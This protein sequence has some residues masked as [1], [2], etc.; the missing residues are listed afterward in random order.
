MIW[1][2]GFPCSGKTTLGYQLH[3]LLKNS[4]VLD[5]DEIRKTFNADLGRRPEDRKEAHRRITEVAKQNLLTHSF[6]I[7]CVVSPDGALRK[8]ARATM[9]S[10]GHRFVEV[11]VKAPIS[12]CIDR[13][14]KGMYKKALSG[15]D[16]RMPGL[17]DS[18]DE[19]DDAEVICNTDQET[20]A[21]SINKIV[22]YLKE[23][24]A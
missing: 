12:V 1:L 21:Q 5:G 13:D 15:E 23:C 17:N 14:I 8:I 10:S 24:R 4:I 9:E 2:T 3:G 22:A 7:V 6:V 20:I 16:F 18:Y 11:Y 19:P